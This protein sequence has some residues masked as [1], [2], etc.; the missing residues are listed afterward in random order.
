MT[1]AA[2][3]VLCLISAAVCV[4]WAAKGFCE[5][6]WEAASAWDA[7]GQ[8]FAVISYLLTR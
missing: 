1:D 8:M 7:A 6:R 4:A 5:A 3:P 2:F